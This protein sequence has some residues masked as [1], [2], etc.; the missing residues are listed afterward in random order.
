MPL[1]ADAPAPLTE[2]CGEG[3]ATGM[4]MDRMT[5][6]DA[7]F[8]S[9]EDRHAALHIGSVAVFEGPAPGQDEI[10]GL[11]ERKLHL[12]TRYRQRMRRVP[13]ALGRPVWTDDPAF[14]L[15]YHLRR[16]AVAAPGGDKE[17]RRLVGRLMS[18]RLD[19]EHPLWESWIVEGLADGRWAMLSKLHH[20]MVDGI[21]GL[22]VLGTLLD[23]RPDPPLF[24]PVD[25]RPTHQ[26]SALA[27]VGTSLAGSALTAVSRSAVWTAGAARHP[28][29][30]VTTVGTTVAGLRH[31]AGAVRPTAVNS[32]AGPI[33][34]PR[35]FRY[36][37]VALSDVAAVREA[38]GGSVNDVVLALVTRGLRDLLV[39]RGE[40]TRP[41]D[42]RCL[43]P[44]SVRP[45]GDHRPAENRVSALLLD[46]PV[47]FDDPLSRYHAV[48]RRTHALKTS[49]EAEAGEVVTEL[50]ELVPSPILTTTL[51]LAFRAPQRVLTT[52]VTNVPGSRVPLYAVG[53]RMIAHYP[54]VPIADRLRVGVAVTSYDGSLYFGLTCDRASVPDADVIAEGIAAELTELS[55]RTAQAEEA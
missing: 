23:D 40:P 15:D 43:V 25:W 7:G 11:F 29:R 20:S 42:V 54:Y 24:P 5:P 16:T 13:L 53:R 18:Q 55:A 47:E 10:R 17:L 3:T 26:P 39:T 45:P 2:S 21:A 51:W 30:A 46:L 32:L 19:P 27:L 1:G 44:V 36:T 50:A 4:L 9:L 37:S 12:L 8:W 52:V 48:R 14:D 41:H 34:T 28:A 49:H 38:L 22:N 35:R 6:L 33:G 31:F